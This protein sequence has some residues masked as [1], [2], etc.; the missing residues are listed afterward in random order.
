MIIG[1]LNPLQNREDKGNLWENFLITERLK[2]KAYNSSLAKG[3]FWRTVSQ[4][5]IDY[6]EEDA[7]LIRGYEIKWNPKSKVKIP[8]I[9]S[10]TYNA[11][12][13]TINQENFRDFLKL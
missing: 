8:K 2:S 12:V 1:N 3:Y 7:G 11:E 10:D 9:F 6:V 4:Q 5:E 13:Q